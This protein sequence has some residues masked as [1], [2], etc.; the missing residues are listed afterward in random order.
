[1]SA[2]AHRPFKKMNGLGNKIIVL[3]LRGSHIVV[4]PAEARAINKGQ[5][6]SF[7]QLMILHD[8]KSLKSEAFVTILNSDGSAAEACGNGTRC[9]AWALSRSDLR[10]TINLETA[11]G[12]LSCTRGSGDIFSVDMGTARFNWDEIP[13]RAP[14]SDTRSVEMD[15]L[16]EGLD[17]P[18]AVNVGNPHAVFWVSDLRKYDLQ[19]IGPGLETHPMFPA[20]ANI[21]LAQIVSRSHVRIKVWERGA[22]ETLAC[23][24]AACATAA[25]A[26]RKGLMD[27]KLHVSLPGGDLSIEIRSSDNHVLMSGP[28]EFEFE[29]HL[30]PQLFTSVPRSRQL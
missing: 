9:V 5:G 21:S 14:C 19:D 13:L 3:D 6:L 24:T 11:A 7:D 23:G 22:G 1:M 20:K 15:D 4:S 26:V 12:L 28:V 2:L 29:G 16:P 27:N 18:S 25:A 8:P 17:A 10:H 30:Q